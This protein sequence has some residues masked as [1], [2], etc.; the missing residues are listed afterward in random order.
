MSALCISVCWNFIRTTYFMKM[1]QLIKLLFWDRVSLVLFVCCSCDRRTLELDTERGRRFKSICDET[2]QIGPQ[3]FHKVRSGL[4]RLNGFSW[5]FHIL[6]W[7]WRETL[8]VAREKTLK[9]KFTKDYYTYFD[10]ELCK[11]FKSWIHNLNFFL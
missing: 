5:S 9:S 1:D 2:I 7:R 3:Q 10:L 11:L 4:A 8:K 6:F